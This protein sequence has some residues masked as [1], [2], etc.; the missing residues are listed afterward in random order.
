MNKASFLFFFI[1]ALS[2]SSAQLN[3]QNLPKINLSGEW[4]FKADP[5][6]KGISES[7]FLKKLDEKV[8]LPGSMTTNGKGDDISLNTPWIGSIVDSSYFRKPE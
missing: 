4:R 8:Q 5:E 6:D 1:L 3:A 2:C 7:W